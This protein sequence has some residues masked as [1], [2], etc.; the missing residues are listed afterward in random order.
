MPY[1][2]DV[3]TAGRIVLMP[4][5]VILVVA[6]EQDRHWGLVAVLVYAIV[7]ASDVCDGRIARRSGHASTRGRWLDHLADIAFLLPALGVYVWLHVMPWWVPASIA[8]A[9]AFY[10]ADSHWRNPGNG[11]VPL[12]SRI[13][14]IGGVSN[15]V[16][17]GVMVCNRSAGIDLL[18]HRF[19]F[20]L[21]CLVPIYSFAAVIARLSSGIIPRDSNRG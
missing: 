19:L 6:A 1:A 17:T 14:H 7:A 10:A 2:A 13:G 16:L 8:I 15:Y 4:V 21:F 18:P 3:L 20:L 12:A 11:T 9:F 5:F